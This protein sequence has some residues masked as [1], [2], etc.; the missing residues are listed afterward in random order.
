MTLEMGSSKIC[1]QEVLPAEH[2]KHHVD[3]V[4]TE[5]KSSYFFIVSGREWG[6]GLSHNFQKF[7]KVV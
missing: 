5:E 6:S 1:K 7:N 4:G 3:V 2:Q